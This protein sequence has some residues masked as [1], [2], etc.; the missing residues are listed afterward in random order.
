VWVPGRPKG[1]EL[2]HRNLI[3]NLVQTAFRDRLNI[4]SDDVWHAVLPMYVPHCRRRYQAL[5]G[6]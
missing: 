4:S 6:V 2:T 3:A 5:V 1:V